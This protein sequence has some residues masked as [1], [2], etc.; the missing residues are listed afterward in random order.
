MYRLLVFYGKPND[1][2]H[3]RSYYTSTHIPLAARL[4]GLKS[5]RYSLDVQGLGGEAPYFCIW[6]A[7]FESE[8]AMLA[9]LESQAGR[10]VAGDVQNYASGGAVVL[11]YA[12]A[13]DSDG[14]Q[15]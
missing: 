3:F 12:L 10:A 2:E 9:A 8:Q 6:E 15:D 1:P 11:H 5:M 13:D 4:P 14:Q 7:E